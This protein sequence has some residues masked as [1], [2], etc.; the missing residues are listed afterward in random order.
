MVEDRR[1]LRTYLGDSILFFLQ[2]EKRTH[3]IS[4]I[5]RVNRKPSLSDV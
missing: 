2:T 1:W 5:E 4:F 3:I